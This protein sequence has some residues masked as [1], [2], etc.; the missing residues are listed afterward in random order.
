MFY[1]FYTFI[2]ATLV[3]AM[4]IHRPCLQQSETLLR[5]AYLLLTPILFLAILH[6]ESWMRRNLYDSSQ[7]DEERKQKIVCS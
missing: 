3:V 6:S 5:K 2:M 7:D 4:I 1:C